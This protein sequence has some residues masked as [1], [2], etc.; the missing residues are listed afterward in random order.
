MW[1]RVEA[2]GVKDVV[3]GKFRELYKTAQDLSEGYNK[4]YG[5]ERYVLADLAGEETKFIPV[6]YTQNIEEHD[7][8]Y[9]V[10][11]NI[12]KYNFSVEKSKLLQ[13]KLYFFEA[14]ENTLENNKTVK[15]ETGNIVLD[16]LNKSFGLNLDTS[17]LAGEGNRIRAIKNLISTIFYEEDKKDLYSFKFLGKEFSDSKIAD[18]MIGFAGGN[19]MRLNIPN[20][21]V[22]FV[23]GNL[24]G[25]I[26]SV[27]GQNFSAKE[28][29]QAGSIVKGIDFQKAIVSDWEKTSDKSLIGQM[30]DLFDPIQGEFEDEYGKKVSWS[31]RRNLNKL[32]FSGKIYG[33]WELQ[34][35]LFVAMMKAKK[36]K[37]GD[38]MISLYDAF[39]KTNTGIP[40]LKDGVEFTMDDVKNFSSKIHAVNKK[41][42]GSY[43]KFDKMLIEKYSIGRLLAFM[44][45]FFFPLMVNRLGKRR[46]DIEE[47]QLV[48]GHYRTFYNTVIK[49]LWEYRNKI[50]NPTESAI[51]SVYRDYKAGYYTEAEMANIKKTLVE[52]G[53]FIAFTLLLALAFS[54]DGDKDRSFAGLYTKYLLLKIRRELGTTSV[55]SPDETYSMTIKQPF[56]VANSISAATKLLGM[57]VVQPINWVSD[58]A[59]GDK[60]LYYQRKTAPFWEEGDS[61]LLAQALKVAGIKV[62][63][64]D[65]KQ[66]IAG[67]NYQMNN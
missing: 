51:A 34:M 2:N 22:N 25:Y 42:N 59:V 50:L 62:N 15:P 24:Q 35:S 30:I 10:F 66:L 48:E 28:F 58:G 29:R 54:D 39:E 43:A 1:E 11:G 55:F 32:L 19:I 16:K 14:L 60:Y 4:D 12:L 63:I 46:L 33:E 52:V 3:R 64:F 44:K 18:K 47:G 41:L 37:Q 8:S 5:Q 21:I 67:Y 23:S 9:D 45:K 38:K 56:F 57:A 27:G 13:D 20:W 49:D 65:P 17:I 36:V 31:K 53:A 61:K 6:K 26:E 40:K 7:Q